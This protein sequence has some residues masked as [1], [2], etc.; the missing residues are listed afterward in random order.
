MA[1]D[2]GEVDEQD[3]SEEHTEWTGLKLALTDW[4][5]WWLAFA[6]LALVISLS[7]NAYFPS[8]AFRMLLIALPAHIFLKP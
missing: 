1:E 4:K 7:F 2:V 5:V 3:K 8:K 6:L